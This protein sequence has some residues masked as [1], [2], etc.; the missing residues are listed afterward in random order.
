MHFDIFLTILRVPQVYASM[1]ACRQ[2]LEILHMRAHRLSSGIPI[3][4]FVLA[5]H[6]AV[7]R[8]SAQIYNITDLGTLGGS[9]ATAHGIN[10]LGQVTGSA[11]LLHDTVDHAFLYTRGTM[12]DLGS[13]GGKNSVGLS[14]NSFGQ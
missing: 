4:V 3:F 5:F 12:K 10:S 14:T 11:N 2:R 7:A 13:L 8:S 6:F 1:S 9:S